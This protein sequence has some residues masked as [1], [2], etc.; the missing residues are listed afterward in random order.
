MSIQS[1]S[2][3]LAGEFLLSDAEFHEI[4][5]VV[6]RTTGIAL[7]DTKRH[8]VYGRLA[9]RLRALSLLTF[10][11]YLQ[12]IEHDASEL[13][14]FCNAIT[15]N[16]T[17]FFRESHHF[18]YLKSTALPAL[19]TQNA[20]LRRI[21]IWSAGC[22]TGEEPY[23]IACCVREVFGERC[24]WDIRILATDLDSTVLAHGEA[25]VYP[26]DRLDKVERTRRDRWFTARNGGAQWAA[27][28]ELRRLIS[29]RRLNLMEP[30]PMKGPFDLIFCRNVVIY[31]DKETQRKLFGRMADLQRAGGHLFIGH[32]ESLFNVCDRYELIGQTT[33]R[34]C[35]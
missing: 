34:K 35:G 1:A 30:W 3:T 19:Q 23:S 7:A 29:F 24:D 27:R 6:H 33:Y 18:Q 15:T 2:Q 4:R 8:L 17:S 13:E 5:R 25:G 12:R 26:A 21:R 14:E 9:R 11:Q 20:T 32:S 16:L 31:F 22:S 28:D 10:R